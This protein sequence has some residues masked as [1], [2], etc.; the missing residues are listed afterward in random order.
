MGMN[1]H[2]RGRYACTHAYGYKVAWVHVVGFIQE[3][4]LYTRCRNEP[5]QYA[6]HVVATHLRTLNIYDCG[7]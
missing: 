2:T 3:S 7:M 1:I 5:K 6:S 4:T